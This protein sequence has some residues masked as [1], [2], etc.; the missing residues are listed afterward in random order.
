MAHVP[1][2]LAMLPAAC[3]GAGARLQAPQAVPNPQSNPHP[4]P[5]PD[6]HPN[7]HPNPNPDA[8]GANLNALKLVEP[9]K[10][11]PYVSALALFDPLTLVAA[12]PSTLERFFEV[13]MKEVQGT[14]HL[15]IGTPSNAGTCP[16]AL[17]FGRA[18]YLCTR[19]LAR[20]LLDSGRGS[21]RGALPR[22][23]VP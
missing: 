11:W 1:R 17:W 5:H 7:P 21:H 10:I 16:C 20:R 6:P 14:E 9:A 8:A 19:L 12:C 3:S 22:H 18:C 15:V 23:R 2:I 13:V 4:N